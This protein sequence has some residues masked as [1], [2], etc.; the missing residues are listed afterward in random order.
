LV[1]LDNSELLRQQQSNSSGSGNGNAPAAA[2][3]KVN[4]QEAAATEASDPFERELNIEAVGSA[5]L[6][7]AAASCSANG[8]SGGGVGGGSSGELL[9][10]SKQPKSPWLNRIIHW[11]TRVL[12]VEVDDVSAAFALVR[13]ACAQT[14]TTTVVYHLDMS[15]I[16]RGKSNALTDT[17]RGALTHYT[18]T[19]TRSFIHA[20]MH[21][22]R[23]RR[24]WN[25]AA[26][27]SRPTLNGIKQTETCAA[28]SSAYQSLA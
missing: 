9:C 15:S 19:H 11:L 10:R 4:A 26:S 13:R 22:V 2:K 23:A 16:D 1:T 28:Y 5:S 25:C 3:I 18:H 20:C 12:E 17:H 7:G 27:V 8:S 14:H 24:N 6:A 21:L